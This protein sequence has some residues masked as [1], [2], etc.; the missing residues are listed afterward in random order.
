MKGRVIK[1]I[2]NNLEKYLLTV[3]FGEVLFYTIQ[4][5]PEKIHDVFNTLKLRASVYIKINKQTKT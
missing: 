4:K 1:K 5:A 2:V 3:K